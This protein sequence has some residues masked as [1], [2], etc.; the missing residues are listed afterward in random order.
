MR[1]MGLGCASTSTSGTVHFSP[2]GPPRAARA[3]NCTFEVFSLRPAQGYEE[4]GTLNLEPTANL[5]SPDR[6]PRTI[7]ALKERIGPE[8]C[9]AGADAVFAIPTLQYYIQVTL[10]GAT[11]AVGAAPA[12]TD[13]AGCQFDTQ[14]KGDRICVNHAC[15][16]P[17]P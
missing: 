6:L 8:V 10:L 1:L 2:A 14:C 7:A 4:V 12:S 11:G 5:F 15:T 9:R 3:N 17:R 13:D 16:A